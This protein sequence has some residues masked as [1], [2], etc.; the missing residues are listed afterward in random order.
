MRQEFSFGRKTTTIR[1]DDCK[2]GTELQM[3][4]GRMGY[5]T[6][7]ETGRR[8]LV[9]ALIF[10]AV[11]SRHQFVWLTYHQKTQDVIEGCERAWAFF[12][13]VFPI[14]IPDNLKAVVAKAHPL[15]PVF[16]EAFLDYAQARDTVLD[17][18]RVRDPKGKPRVERAVPYVREAFYRGEDFRDLD[19]ANRLADI[20]CRTKAGLRNHGT[21]QRRPLEVFEAEARAQLL[22]APETPYDV[23]IYRDV[24]VGISSSGYILN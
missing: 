6:D 9:W 10:T 16:T 14:L 2:P 22:P 12:D 18:T 20:W 5:L 21:T 17:P 24:C 19:D 15:K 13:G 23:P 7:Q 4:F 1:V 3:D 11:Y 8:A